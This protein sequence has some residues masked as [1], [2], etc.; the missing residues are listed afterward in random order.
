M[1]DSA[2][3]IEPSA[4]SR[5]FSKEFK[6]CSAQF[7][8]S[9]WFCFWKRPVDQDDVREIQSLKY[10]WECSACGG[11]D[12]SHIRLETC[13]HCGAAFQ[14]PARQYLEPAGFRVDWYEKPHADTDNV[15]VVPPERPRVSVRSAAWQ[16][17]ID[18]A[19]GRLRASHDGLVFYSSIGRAHRGYRVCL[20]CGRTAEDNADGSNPLADH[21]P[22]RGG[23]KGGDICK[24]AANP[25]SVTAAIALGHQMRTDVTEVQPADLSDPGAAWALAS[26]LR[27]ALSRRLGIENSELGLAV[28]KRNGPMGQDT[29]SI[30][31]YDSA[32][33]GAGFATSLSEDLVRVLED[34]RE[35]LDCTAAGCE[36]GCASCVITKDLYEG[37]DIVDRRAGLAAAE[38]LLSG[39]RA[40][41]AADMSLPGA[42]FSRPVADA[43]SMVVR[44]MDTVT[45]FTAGEF[46]L[47]IFGDEPFTT[48]FSHVKQRRVKLRV[49]IPAAV[50]D[51][52]SPAERLGVRDAAI[53]NGF[54]VLRWTPRT[55]SNGASWLALLQSSSSATAWMSRD[56]G[57][58]V[59]GS[60][61]G[62]GSTHPIVSGMSAE[63]PAIAPIDLDALLP[64]ADAA[65]L[66]FEQDKGVMAKRFGVWIVQ[67]LRTELEKL[68]LWRPSELIGLS[69]SDR[70]FR[71]PLVL[72]LALRTFAAL[73]DQLGM[74]NT[75]LPV[76]IK[77][78]DS[79]PQ[80]R[81][82][83]LI[84]HDWRRNE[85]RKAVAAAAAKSFGLSL[86]WPE[87]EIP[88]ARVLVLQY[89]SGTKAHLFWDQGFGHWRTLKNEKFDFLQSP[90]GQARTLLSIDPLVCGRGSTHITIKAG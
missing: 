34:A 37:Q 25:F 13:P 56:E 24:G 79:D 82:P 67:K 57:A 70:Y 30:Y 71:S 54:G 59:F 18:P 11:A 12:C 45:L 40:P 90:P 17:L 23:K 44:P 60:E 55:A 63:L 10:F 9:S 8:S 53:R 58:A 83:Y 73:R 46:D 31:L 2:E 47:A 88:H 78:T 50:I 87:G 61:W 84:H 65:V 52:L 16:P 77:G 26:A 4:S 75:V 49:A 19:L 74:P 48:M 86:Q 72:M 28:E 76:E 39:M 85:D 42:A 27:E 21:I 29:H 33:G 3:A 64:R 41:D 14:A 69:Y 1:R 89:R 6:P 68:D 51:A 22:L 66:V 5:R 35:I 38:R 81:S 20:F 32:E 62:K 43:L 7:S 15:E 36:R 80:D